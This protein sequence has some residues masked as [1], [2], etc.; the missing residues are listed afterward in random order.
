MA[1]RKSRR[2]Q[3][4]P[5]EFRDSFLVNVASKFGLGLIVIVVFLTLVQ[6]SI[7]KPEAPAWNTQFT[8]PVINRTY[9]MEELVDKIDQE[10][11][12]ISDDSTVVYSFSDDIDT[13]RLDG[14]H[15]TT[16][17]L[18]YSIAQPV[19][20]IRL[21]P[22]VV[23]PVSTDY[24]D[25]IGLA[26]GAV[27]PTSFQ[28]TSDLPPVDSYQQATI[29]TARLWVIVDN[30]LGLD[31][32]QVDVTLRDVTMGQVVGTQSLTGGIADGDSDSLS[33]VLDS[34]TISNEFE[35]Q[36]DCHTPGGT[37]LS[38]SD[39]ALTVAVR[40]D[41]NLS[42]SSGVAKIPALTRAFD[43]QV[44][45]GETDPV[46]HATLAAGQLLLTV[47][48]NTAL[49]A[50][51][52][53]ILPDVVS[54]GQPLSVSQ[55]VGPNSSDVVSVNIAGYDLVPTDS[56]VPQQ[57][58]VDV[59][60]SLPGS[61]DVMVAVD[62]TDD[63]TVTASLTGLE[64]SSITGRFAGTDA[65]IEPTS[66]EID[67]P[68]GF[69]Q[70]ELQHAIVTLEVEN[71]VN[72]AGTVDLLLSGDNGKSHV[73]TGDIDAGTP[74][75]ATVTMIVDSTVADFLSPLP[76]RIDIS[77]TAVFGDGV[78]VSTVNA[79]DFVYAQV[80][81]LAPLEFVLGETQIDADIEQEEVEQDD[82]DLITEHVIEARFVYTITNHLPLGVDIDIL[83]GGDSTTVMTNPGL[84]ISGLGVNAAPVV[85]GL[86][87]DSVTSGEQVI[88][89]DSAD[90]QVLK[91]DTLYVGQQITL[92]GTD[93][94]VV[95][96]T[97]NDWLRVEGYLQVE[98]RF[99]G[100]F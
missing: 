84:T 63:F 21:D 72:M 39:K 80:H 94:Q 22:P 93:G 28:I 66:Q 62:E 7:K 87:S 100:E 82:I 45:L 56:T 11:I 99:D 61:G 30:D 97:T 14:E 95:R 9:P 90:I 37:V 55:P 10:G 76:G 81:I 79:D 29:A 26:A 83:L 19:G 86:V 50:V 6:C 16:D 60:A 59:T 98:Y 49:D 36:S 13:V 85:A 38:A 53:I 24:M 15:L 51:L 88:V 96:L 64:F 44:D 4:G 68:E 25:I 34:R 47:S 48:N 91:N 2:Q 20:L 41:E 78:T 12:E 73:F 58:T 69:D 65:T 35:V 70:I 42:V 31:L 27:P 23:D 17:D 92:H 77:G 40:F 1:R 8:V 54:G 32:D 18:S 46:Y 74:G 52:D 57:V 5:R 89:L 3:D 75:G 67:V 33:F 71:H 43:Q